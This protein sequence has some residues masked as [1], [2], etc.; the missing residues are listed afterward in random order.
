[1]P[2][3]CET[4]VGCCGWAESQSAYFAEFRAI[5]IQQSFYQPPRLSTARRWREAAPAG[6]AFCM[7]AWQLIT[8]E[9]S[10]PTYRRLSKPIPPG[11]KARYGGFRGTAE[12][13]QAWQ[14]TRNL[15]EVLAARVVLFQCPASFSPIQENVDNLCRF[16]EQ[17]DRSSMLAAWE[18]RGAWQPHQIRDLCARLDLIDAVD[19]FVRS[20]TNPRAC[21]YWRLHGIGGYRHRFTD[22]DLETLRGQLTT[23]PTFVMFNNVSMLADARRFRDLLRA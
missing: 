9:P 20:A 6:F 1:M 7:K 2:R 15:A 21:R 23:M 16:F 13:R 8:H 5:E 11:R 4:L 19:P 18:P 17:I 3:E 14:V 10:S 12:V 22:D